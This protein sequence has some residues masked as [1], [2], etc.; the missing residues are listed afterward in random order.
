MHQLVHRRHFGRPLLA[1]A[2]GYAL[3]ALHGVAAQPQP[4]TQMPGFIVDAENGC[5]TS[6]PIPRLGETIRWSGDCANGLLHGQ[7][8]LLWLRDGKPRERN[9]G[10]FL[11]GELDGQASTTFA[12]GT[13][14][15]GQYRRGIRHG[16]FILRRPNGATIRAVYADG[17][18]ISERQM[19]ASEMRQMRERPP[20]PI[21]V[22]PQMQAQLP[23]QYQQ[24][25]Y[26]APPAYQ[27]QAAYTPPAYVPPVYV[28]TTVA[29]AVAPASTGYVSPWSPSA[30]RGAAAPV[31]QAPAYQ[32][33][34][35]YQAPAY[36]PP[37][38]QQPA[39]QAPVYQAAPYPQPVSA[40]VMYEASGRVGALGGPELALGDAMMLERAGRNAE[41]AQL[42]GQIAAVAGNTATGLLANERAQRLRSPA[43][44]M[45]AYPGAALPLMGTVPLDYAE[46]RQPLAGR[47]ICTA[48]NI[49]AKQAN[50]CGRVLREEGNEVE[51][52][53]RSLRLNSFFA[54]GFSSAPCTGNRFLSIFSSGK[55]IW[56][57]RGCLG[58]EL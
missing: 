16:E 21:P 24:Q 19:E 13:L 48:P 40:S 23:P 32:Q 50:W 28:P 56:V 43:V 12:D 30:Y 38:Y 54:I 42:Y 20:Q 3:M 35:A 39:Y 15:V 6:N 58:G 7:G 1:A 49:F 22:Q 17:A 55:R 5:A 2:A 31:Y 57:S 33:V 25:V 53:V 46:R 45:V 4:A 27:P 34:P 9:E 47:Y 11:A 18:L 52:E 10:S 41:A 29:P 37:A 44:Q 14:L 36:Q 8:T 26:Q 51:V